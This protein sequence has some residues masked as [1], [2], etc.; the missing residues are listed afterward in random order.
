[1]REGRADMFAI[2]PLMLLGVAVVLVAAMPW[3]RPHP[4]HLFMLELL[5]THLQDGSEL[6]GNPAEAQNSR[7]ITAAA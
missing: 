5:K 1:M 2:L 6:K 7:D 4:N 3:H